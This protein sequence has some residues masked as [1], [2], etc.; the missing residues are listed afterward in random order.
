MRAGKCGL[1]RDTRLFVFNAESREERE[2]AALR[3]GRPL[4][5]E[6]EDGGG[7]GRGGGGAALSQ[8][9][10]QLPLDQYP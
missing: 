9:A 7:G 1:V 2:E 10:F 8:A 6:E 3:R 4:I 5:V